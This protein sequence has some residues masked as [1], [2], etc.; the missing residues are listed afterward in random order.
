MVRNQIKRVKRTHTCPVV[1]LQNF[2]KVSPQYYEK[3]KYYNQKPKRKDFTV[4]VHDKIQ[5]SKIS[6]RSLQ[7]IGVR[8]NFYS[9]QVE[10]YLKKLE[11][12]VGS[13]FKK[14]RMATRAVFVELLPIYRYIMSQLVR[15]PKFQ[16]KLRKDQLFLM[17]MDD[18]EFQESLMKFMLVH[19]PIVVTN[20]SLQKIQEDFIQYNLLEAN[21]KRATITLITNYTD[22]PFITSDSPVVYN[23][24]EFLPSYLND[25]NQIH[26][27]MIFVPET[28]FYIPIDPRFSLLIDRFNMEREEVAVLDE[29]VFDEE[30]V[31]MMNMLEY[32]YSER[33][34]YLKDT[35]E[36]LIK[37]IRR[38][39]GIE[40]DKEYQSLEYSY[41]VLKKESERSFNK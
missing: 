36:E 25:Q 33:F 26:Y 2:A 20:A 29:F 17:K 28:R 41:N 16:E 34:I 22:I 8:K 14:I 15:T 4:Y 11:A 37:K 18:K 12:K 7:N 5:N 19:K 40:L 21:F 23:N 9:P 10:H 1:Y 38:K 31:M 32:Q 39:C 30:L 24:V 13:Q 35:D 3:L 27:S 6:N